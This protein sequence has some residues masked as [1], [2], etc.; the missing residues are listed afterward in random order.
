MTPG[1]GGPQG[2][3]TR[4]RRGGPAQRALPSSTFG[5]CGKLLAPRGRPGRPEG[6]SLLSSSAVT[7]LLPCPLVAKRSGRSWP[8]TGGF[9][10]PRAS[11]PARGEMA[12]QPGHR[13][14]P[15]T[16]R[17]VGVSLPSAR[18]DPGVLGRGCRS[19]AGGAPALGSSGSLAGP[20]PPRRRGRAG[21][22]SAGGRGVGGAKRAS[23]SPG[24]APRS[25]VRLPASRPALPSRRLRSCAPRWPSWPRDAGDAGRCAPGTPGTR[26]GGLRG[27]RDA[28]RCAPSR[29]ARCAASARVLATLAGHSARRRGATYSGASSPSLPYGRRHDG[30]HGFRGRSAPPR[31]PNSS[32]STKVPYRL[33]AARGR[34]SD[35]AFPPPM[36]GLTFPSAY[37]VLCPVYIH[38][39]TDATHSSYEKCVLSIFSLKG[40]ES[41]L[42]RS[43]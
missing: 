9:A 37:C 16:S 12:L 13:P 6:A 38:D 43:K 31:F 23:S 32:A 27:R 40:R 42:G 10:G 18:G 1:G 26:A 41:R 4:S 39:L 15:P 8:G 36:A 22:A 25:P 3:E 28:G 5:K 19:D 11:V 34:R 24:P 17:A 29:E 14:L 7:V 35:P 2:A 21:P 20:R 33:D 30:G